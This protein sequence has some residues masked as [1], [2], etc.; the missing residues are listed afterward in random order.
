MRTLLQ[1]IITA[2]LLALGWEKSF[3]ERASELPFVGDKFGSSEKAKREGAKPSLRAVAAE[4]KPASN[5]AWMFDPN[6]KTALDRPSP[7]PPKSFTGHIT[8]TD[9]NGKS[10]W[11]DAQGTRHYP[12]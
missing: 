8:Y 5:G 1:V 10:Y 2:A 6:H 4:A 3:K 9:E 7:T 12:P 11:L